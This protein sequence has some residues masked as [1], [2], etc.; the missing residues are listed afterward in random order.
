MT[1]GRA[2]RHQALALLAALDRCE[3]GRHSRDSCDA[4]PGGR[5]SGNLFLEA[6]TRIGTTL[7]G[8]AIV[9][10]AQQDRSDPEA[11]TEGTPR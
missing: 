5:S 4:C 10:P 8:E 1:P 9:V 6:G 3:H 11:W 2:A 7:H